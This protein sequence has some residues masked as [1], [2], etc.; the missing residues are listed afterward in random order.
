MNRRQSGLLL[1]VTSLPSAFGIGDLGPEAFRFVDFLVGARQRIWQVLPLGPTGYADSPYQSFSAFAGNPLLI[2]PELLADEG[3]L[4]S[5]DLHGPGFAHGRVDFETV[6]PWRMALLRKAFHRHSREA[7]PDSRQALAL[8][9]CKEA[10]WL[11]DFALFMAIKEQQPAGDWTS[12]R[13]ELCHRQPHALAHYGE[14]YAE[15]VRF[16]QFA[17][18]LFQRQWSDLRRYANRNEVLILGDLPIFVAHDSCDVWAHPSLFWLD[19]SGQPSRVAGVPP[20][21]FSAT[22]Q[23]WGNPLYRWE[24]MARTGFEWWVNRMAAA[25][26]LVDLVRVDHFRGFEA[27]WEIPADLPTATV[28]AWVPGPGAALFREMSRRLGTLPILAEDLGVITPAV[29]GMRDELEYPGMRVLQFAFGNDPKA[30]DY[31]PHNYVRNCAVYTGTHDNDTAVG[32]F[33]SQAGRG[34]TLT[35][36]EVSTERE[37]ALRYLN[38]NGR[39]IQWDLIRAAWASVADTAIAPVQDVLGLGS[40]AR[41]NLPGSGAGNWRWRLMPDTLT[42]DVARRL[43]EMAEVY[44]R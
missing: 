22:G 20:D 44:E 41:M 8:F 4:D 10:A 32:W 42:P 13:P 27:A 19:G 17:Q 16:H 40:E 11:D 43:A 24:Q 38:S 39:E 15:E 28:G 37:F 18:W 29:E 14:E 36:S 25:L 6:V 21:Y 33:H 1:H 30:R 35:E 3:W 12:W 7:G 34:S 31:Q 26:K 2:S 5:A 9:C 23:R